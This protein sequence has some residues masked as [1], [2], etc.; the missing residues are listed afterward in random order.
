[1]RYAISHFQPGET[2]DHFSNKMCIQ[3][4]LNYGIICYWAHTQI[5]GNLG[6][7]NEGL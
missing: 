7:M 6:T 1:M 5:Y 3:M 4:L 2:S